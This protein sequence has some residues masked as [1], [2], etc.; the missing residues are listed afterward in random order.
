MYRFTSPGW[1]ELGTF[2]FQENESL[3]SIVVHIPPP[4]LSRLAMMSL[5]KSLSTITS[6]AFSELV[7]DLGS[8]PSEPIQLPFDTH[9]RGN[10]EGVDRL[11]NGFLDQCPDFKLVIRAD[12]QCNR[13][14]FRARAKERFPLMAGRD[15]IR[16]ETSPGVEMYWCKYSTTRFVP[17]ILRIHEL[18][19]LLDPP[20]SRA[21]RV[22]GS[23]NIHGHKKSCGRG[24][25][26]V[27]TA[28]DGER[29][30]KEDVLGVW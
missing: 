6:P 23:A 16:F 21:W 7:L 3:R 5:R 28:G 17:T 4:D 9:R 26:Y 15:R 18:I 13:G 30:I 27:Q 22:L 20:P 2:W 10:W 29:D 14:E 11:L 1:P 8:P 24:R 19:R 25:R 12:A